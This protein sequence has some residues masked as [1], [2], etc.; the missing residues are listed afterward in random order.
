MLYGLSQHSLKNKTINQREIVKAVEL[1]DVVKS[2]K[3]IWVSF[4]AIWIN[5]FEITAGKDM[6]CHGV[7]LIKSVRKRVLFVRKHLESKRITVYMFRINFSN[8]KW[9]SFSIYRPSNPQ[10][11][12][13]F[14]LSLFLKLLLHQANQSYHGLLNTLRR[15]WFTIHKNL[16]NF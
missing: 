13:Y 6:H 11:L 14:F 3:K 4:R 12:G 15:P 16:Q 7:G 5:D 9:T 2:Q 8:K 10:N 1:H